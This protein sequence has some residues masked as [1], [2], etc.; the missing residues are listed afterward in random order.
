MRLQLLLLGLPVL[1]PLSA[2]AADLPT[3]KAPPLFVQAAPN[4]SGFYAGSFVGAAIGEFT[5]SAPGSASASGSGAGFTIGALAGYN[6]QTGAVVYGLEGDIGT[7]SAERKVNAQTGLVASEVENIYSLH[8]RAR[9]G[10]DL[11]WFM[12]FI[13][14]GV[15]YG[16]NEQFQRGALTFDG[17]TKNQVG[18]T[19]GAGVDAKVN[20][21]LLGPSVLRGEYLY[22]SY[23]ATNF[24]LNGPIMHTSIADHMFRVALISRIGEAW[25]PPAN[26][27]QVD[28]AG[29]Y[30]GVIGGGLWDS[31]STSGA[32]GPTTK[33]SASGPIGGV[34]SGHNWTFS[35]AVLGI[36]GATMLGSVTGHG[37]QPGAASTNYDNY[38]QTDL[39][40]RAGYAFGRF[41][42]YFATGVAWGQS[43]QI[44]TA[45]GDNQGLVSA[46]SWTVG[47][48]VEY[49]IAERWSVRAEYLYSRSF[50]NVETHLDSITCCAQTRSNDSF[51]VGLAYFFH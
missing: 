33:F 46:W 4:W 3:K 23:P 11:G 49:L 19:I 21:P 6:W 36:E 34:Y 45:T 43:R 28:W 44:D 39:R 22:D 37:P 12:P 10:Y 14:G 29:D 20:V 13:A 5:T 24:N 17:E 18:W 51:R 16:R 38:F 47:A 42:P 1:A 2:L 9:L 7:T 50:S 48:G 31:L 35:N 40:G 32:L 27:D 26:P 41:L 30:F 25:R 15:V 8:G